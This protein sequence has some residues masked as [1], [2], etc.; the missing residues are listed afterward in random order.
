[1][2]CRRGLV[3]YLEAEFFGGVGMQAHVL[4][5]DGVVLG[6]PVVREDAI[7]QALRHFN[8]RLGSHHDEF[9]A[10]GLG[11]YRDTDAWPTQSG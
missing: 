9:A 11:R 3:A 7:N 4:C 5:R 8:V 1:M 2:L 10:M 6:P